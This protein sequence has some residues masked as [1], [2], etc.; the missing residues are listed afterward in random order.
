[1]GLQKLFHVYFWSK[2]LTPSNFEIEYV[3]NPYSTPIFEIQLVQNL[4]VVLHPKPQPEIGG[5]NQKKTTASSAKHQPKCRE[6][7]DGCVW[8]CQAIGG[9]QVGQVTLLPDQLTLYTAQTSASHQPA[10]PGKVRPKPNQF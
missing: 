1:M 3:R 6:P 8:S 2:N 5:K 4:N 7:T 10:K 9:S